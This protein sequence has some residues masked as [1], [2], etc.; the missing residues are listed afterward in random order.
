MLMIRA[1]DYL[2]F[3]RNLFIM[4]GLDALL[5]AGAYYGAFLIRF[6][7]GIPY[8]IMST[9]TSTW[10]WVLG[11]KLAAFWFFGLYRGMWRYTSLVDLVNLFK[12]VLVSSLTAIV[13]ILW[14]FGFYGYSRSVYLIDFV[15]CFLAVGGTRMAIRLWFARAAG[16]QLFPRFGRR[17][18]RSGRQVLIVGQGDAAEKIIRETQEN[19]NLGMVPVGLLVDDQRSQGKA[20]RGV[21]ILGDIASIEYLTIEYDE[22]LIALA[23]TRGEAMRRVVDLCEKTDKPYRTMPA[24]DELING[25]VSLKAVRNVRVEDLLGRAE[26]RLDQEEIARYLRGKRVLVTGAGGSIGSELVRQIGRFQ[27]EALGLME[28]SEFNLFKVDLEFRQRY[29]DLTAVPFL[30]DIRD[31]ESVDRVFRAFDPQVVFH[32]A[33]YKHVPIQEIFPWEAV[34]NN[35]RGTINLAQAAAAGRVERFVLVSTDKA[36]RPTNVM[37]ATKRVA[38]MVVE[39]TNGLTPV[40]FMAVRF[41]NVM[42]SSGSAIPV[43]REQIARGGPVTVTHPEVTRYF[44]SVGEAAQLILQAGALGTGGEVFILEMGQPIRILDLVRDMI[45][46]SGFEPET[47]I[48]IVFTGLRPGEKLY[49]ELITEGEGIVPTGHEKIM[50]LKGTACDFGE[51]KKRIDQLEALAQTYNAEAIR[52]HLTLMIPEYRPNPEPQ[53]PAVHQEPASP[54][55]PAVG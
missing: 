37:G 50:V 6:E 12:A 22:I 33:A 18:G 45:R 16:L 36:V 4:L 40:R 43:F 54:P 26:L 1:W 44:M 7:F 17:R 47:E 30:S 35:V 10:P 11:L 2:T 34:Q 20:I 8:Y 42:G 39:C 14:L 9:F 51:L 38:E 46:L 48:P 21:P 31:R 5:V 41:G 53:G 55:S 15:L 13:I 25:S 19:P 52:N 49:E 29:P 27:P 24:L 32:A 28:I 3:R 23:H